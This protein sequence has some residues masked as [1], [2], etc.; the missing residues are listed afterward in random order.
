MT[1]MLNLLLEEPL[2]MLE[3]DSKIIK[4][5]NLS[6]I[7]IVQDL[8][9]LKRKNLK[10]LNFTDE[11]IKQIKIKLQLNSIDLNKKIYH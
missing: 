9:H 10:E 7:Y 6:N 3:L 11:E 8:W 4:K 2:Q 1:K 5:L